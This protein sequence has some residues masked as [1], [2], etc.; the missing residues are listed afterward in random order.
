MNI[1][2]RSR[3]RKRIL[4]LSKYKILLLMA[5]PGVIYFIVFHYLPLWGILVAFKDYKPFLGFTKSAWVGMENFQRLAKEPVFWN[6]LANSLII[7]FCNLIF[8]FPLPIVLALLLNE[9]R[10]R[11][12]N[13][14]VQTVLYLPHF[15]SWVIIYG[16]TF[17]LFSNQGLVNVQLCTSS[18]HLGQKWQFA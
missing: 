1:S 13:R 8:F 2:F 12:F 11:F 17:L 18:E 7:N 3:I 4:N 10:C 15:L 16:I 14:T 9:V 5:F 6:V